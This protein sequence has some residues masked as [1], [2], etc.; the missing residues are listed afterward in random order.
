MMLAKSHRVTAFIRNP[1]SCTF[2][3]GSSLVQPWGGEMPNDLPAAKPSQDAQPCAQRTI[4]CLQPLFT[5]CPGRCVLSPVRTQPAS[6]GSGPRLL[7]WTSQHLGW[8]THHLRVGNL[9]PWGEQPIPLCGYQSLRWVL[10]Y[11]WIIE[12]KVSLLTCTMIS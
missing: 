8:S 3:S 12:N 1:G 5:L 2:L 4:R 7:W 9:T 11:P 6:H 10:H